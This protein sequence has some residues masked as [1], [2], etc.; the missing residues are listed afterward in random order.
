[1]RLRVDSSIKIDDAGMSLDDKVNRQA[2]TRK[3]VKRL[4]KQYRVLGHPTLLVL[5]PGGEVVWRDTGYKR[6]E[7]DFTWGL[8]KQARA[9]AAHQ[10]KTWRKQLTSK[11]Y[12]E[13]EGQRGRKVF[14]KLVNYSEGKLIL[15]EPGG[16][17]YKT[18]ESRLSKSDQKWVAEQKK[19]R[20]IE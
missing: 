10:F 1:M 18:D 2:E 20:G 13:W 15:I 14:A 8:I 12:R 4:K 7:A 19:L 3:Y 11:G 6:G 9:A 16:E 17:R 5:N